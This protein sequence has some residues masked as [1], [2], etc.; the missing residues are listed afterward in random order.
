MTWGLGTWANLGA[1]HGWWSRGSPSSSSRLA[2]GGQG[3]LSPAPQCS[4]E[5]MGNDGSVILPQNYVGLEAMSFSFMHLLSESRHVVL[6]TEI[7]KITR[8]SLLS[9]LTWCVTQYFVYLWEH[10][11]LQLH[12]DCARA[13]EA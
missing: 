2:G 11:F 3:G 5:Y 12:K 10:S 9:S 7:K 8:G 1:G 6:C 13:K 4:Q